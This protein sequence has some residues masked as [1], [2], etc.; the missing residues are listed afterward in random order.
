[1][2]PPEDPAAA[3]P[4]PEPAPAE[5]WLQSL[6]SPGGRAPVVRWVAAGGVFTVLNTGLLYVLVSLAGLP[7]A[8]GTLLG[9]EACTLL[10][11]LVNDH[12][13]FGHRRPTWRRLWQ[14]HVANGAAFGIWWGA[15]NLLTLAGMNYLLAGIA[16]VVFSIG[17]SLGSNFLWI[18]RKKHH[19][20][21]AG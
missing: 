14:Y 20:P 17:F 1:M 19:H 13:V 12:W 10:R 6:V 21:P 15:T 11:F 18:W 16:A 3:V 2:P 8:V 4:A 5:S 9:A 7:V